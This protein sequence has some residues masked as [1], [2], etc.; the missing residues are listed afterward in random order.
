MRLDRRTLRRL[1]AQNAVFVVLLLALVALAAW[2]THTWR[3]TADWTSS[4]RNTL[5]PASRDVL[6]LLERPVRVTAYVGPDPVTRRGIRDIVERYRRAGGAVE[7]EFVNPETNPGLARELGLRAGGEVIVRLGEREQRLT[8]I[9]EQTLTNALARLARGRAR[10]IVFLQGH[11]ERDPDG[12]ANFDLRDFGERLRERGLNVQT[13]NLATSP[14]IPDNTDLLVI[15]SPRADYLPG[16]IERI[17][18]HVR[19][20]GRLLWLTEPGAGEHLGALADDL[21]IDRREGVVIDAAAG[22]FGADRPDFAVVGDYDANHPV[23]QALDTLTLFPQAVALETADTPGWSHTELLRTRPE[24]WT[25]TEP[26]AEPRDD[27]EPA[28]PLTIGVAATREPPGT[29][30]G[31][32]AGGQRA[33]SRQRIAVIGDGDFLS[34]AY[35]GNGANLD[36][37]MRLVNWLVGDDEQVRISPQRPPDIDLEL[38]RMALAVVGLGF[39]VVL[40]LALLGAG[41]WI[42]LR[43]RRR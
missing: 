7:L 6:G 8:R 15:A 33:S 34:N 12:G 25:T 37:G 28:G 13:L 17:R 3:H 42:A 14:D 5:A 24:S 40:P 27:A 38:S 22:L 18:G 35:A 29:D 41:A 21:G 30:D 10:W 16:E 26:R 4:G 43:R 23:T 19:A 36:L 32:D 11:G 2:A 31:D 39:L 9:S 1:R 20:G